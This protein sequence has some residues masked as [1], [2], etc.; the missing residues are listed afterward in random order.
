MRKLAQHREVKENVREFSEL[1][2]Q[3]S[4]LG[5]N[6]AFFSFMDGLKPWAKQEL[7]RRGVKDFTKAMIVAESLIELKKSNSTKTKGKGGGNKDGQKKIG[8]GKPSAKGK[9]TKD[10]EKKKERFVC[11]LCEGSHKARDCPKRNKL[12]AIAKKEDDESDKETH[13]LGSIILNSMKAKRFGKRKGLI[14]TDIMVAGTKVTALVDTGASDLFVAE[15][16][17]KRLGLKVSKGTVGLRLS[18][19]KRCQPWEW[20]EELSCSWETGKATRQSR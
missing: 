5:E 13:K 9:S 7:Q 16:T 14:F 4:Y 17:A 6:E 12:S 15:R 2:L 1:M 10:R 19:P 20:H 8:N 18:I 3:I 11:F